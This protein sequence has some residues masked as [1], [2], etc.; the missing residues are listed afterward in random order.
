M[1]WI[2]LYAGTVP[3]NKEYAAGTVPANK[4]YA[5]GTVPANKEYAAGAVPA[6]KEYAAGTP[7]K[8]QLHFKKRYMICEGLLG[9]TVPLNSK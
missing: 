3:A 9:G 6:N 8:L 7:Q 5:A 4:K 2:R 1:K